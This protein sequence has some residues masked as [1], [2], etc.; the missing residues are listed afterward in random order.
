MKKI[1]PFQYRNRNIGPLEYDHPQSIS[2]TGTQEVLS[3]VVQGMDASDIEER[4]ARAL[5]KIEIPFDFRARISSDA[6]GQR[7]LTREFANIKGEVEID[8]LCEKDGAVTPIFVDGE[9]S[10]YFTPAQA[11]ADRIKTNVANEFGRRF[12]WKEAVRIPFW[13]L[14]TQDMADKTIRDIFL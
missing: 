4:T 13:K 3:G 8:M 1:K 5:Y 11:E 7:R 12:G 14:T 9:I 10:H 6:L 2:R